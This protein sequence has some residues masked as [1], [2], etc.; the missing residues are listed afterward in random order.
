MSENIIPAIIALVGVF[1]SIV[2]SATISA[3]Q[4]RIE[5]QKIRN[6]YLH[7]YASKLFDQ[8]M[9]VYPKIFESMMVITQK[10]RLNRPIQPRELETLL[11]FIKIG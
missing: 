11:T 7:L 9:N 3:R 5:T 10:I 8:R 1:I 6:E 4:Y 2:A